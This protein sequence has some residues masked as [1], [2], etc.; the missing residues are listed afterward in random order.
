[1]IYNFLDISKPLE[2]NSI[3]KF[4]DNSPD[5]MHADRPLSNFELRIEN[6]ELNPS[7]IKDFELRILNLALWQI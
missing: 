6:F 5:Y 2:F 4:Q 1:M 3:G 7:A